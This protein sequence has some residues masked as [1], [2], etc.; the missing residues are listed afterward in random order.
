MRAL[1][2]GTALLTACQPVVRYQ[3]RIV[4]RPV[5]YP[6]HCVERVPLAPVFETEGLAKGVSDGVLIMSLYEE[7]KQKGAFI[8]ALLG[9]LQ[10]CLEK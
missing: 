10:N 6:V 7:T 3:D 5:P 9:L 8:D 2:L 1:L 4:D